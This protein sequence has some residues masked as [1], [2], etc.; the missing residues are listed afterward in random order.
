METCFPIPSMKN[1]NLT[2][3]ET[4]VYITPTEQ[5]PNFAKVL[6]TGPLLSENHNPK[7]LGSFP[8]IHKLCN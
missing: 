1:P 5:E 8:S 6:R 3:L 2:E 7:V 4:Y